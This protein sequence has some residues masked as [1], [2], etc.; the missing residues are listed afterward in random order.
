MNNQEW[1]SYRPAVTV[2]VEQSRVQ[3]TGPRCRLAVRVPS[4]EHRRTLLDLQ[5]GP[6]PR[7]SLPTRT[8][9][10]LRRYEMVQVAS[11]EP[12]RDTLELHDRSSLPLNEGLRY[13]TDDLL[14]YQRRA[15]ARRFLPR[16]P[17]EAFESPARR[18]RSFA[19]F[20]HL[21][22]SAPPVD[23][24]VLDAVMRAFHDPERRLYPSAGAL[25][26]VELVC[27]QVTE[28]GSVFRTATGSP[29]RLTE[30][31][32]EPP[33]PGELALDPTLAAVRTR[34]W[35][36]GRLADVTA[37]YGQ[38][39]YRYT[40]LE[41][42]H[43]AQAL[44][45]M[46]TEAGLR[47]R[48]F[49]G[50]DD[51]AVARRLQ[52]DPGTVPLYAIGVL[53]AEPA[54]VWLHGQQVR[55]VLV[56]GTPLYYAE[57][58]G[59]RTADGE[60]ESG[61]GV[62]VS[63]PTALARATGE[64]AE[65]TALVSS[66]RRLGNSNGMAAHV[67][68]SAASDAAVLELYERHCF[69]RLWFRRTAP[70]VLPQPATALARA[71][72]GLCRKAGAE[73]VLTDMTDPRFGV[74]AVMAVA[75]GAGHGGVLIGSGAAGRRSQAVDSALR[76]LAKA[77]FYRVV[78]RSEGA[79]RD[80]DPMPGELTSPAAHEA[81]FAHRQVPPE[82]TAFLTAG[83]PATVD[84]DPAAD[85]GALRSVVTVEDLSASGPDPDTWFVHRATSD[86]LLIVDFCTPSDAFRE[87][88][89]RLAGPEIE[90]D[91]WW[92]HPLG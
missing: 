74:P 89:A 31:A 15:A 16:S 51:L 21:D 30:R 9:E 17:E 43:A 78:L 27:E 82:L 37:K 59:A 28:S 80:E 6:L 12:H 11:H 4:A 84:D 60:R 29:L 24:G 73:L 10:L 68:P 39:G 76:E 36:V 90:V 46:L 40:L 35:L 5:S 34:F 52:L 8:V 2:T 79:F 47:C 62:D 25:Y 65:R 70:E 45:E 1:I 14:E 49:G 71:V 20:D 58:F 85:L 41:A 38:R 64:L 92:P 57:T 69:M 50:F 88:I 63:L 75:R 53:A 44:I 61:Y 23:A 42:G 72:A 22:D 48:P 33:A 81:R 55:C 87:R 66:A 13:T 56:G 54:P 83:P 18:P 67:R 32:A 3:L 26:P 7:A 77:L 86:D 19:P 91:G